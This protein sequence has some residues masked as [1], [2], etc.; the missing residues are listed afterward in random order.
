MGMFCFQCEQTSQGKG[1]SVAGVCGKQPST[2]AMQDL[3]VFAVK[4]ISKYAWAAVQK[5]AKVPDE[6]MQF[7]EGAIFTTITNV[8]FDDQRLIAM[9]NKVAEMKTAAIALYQKAGGKDSLELM[10]SIPSHGTL[11]EYL[12]V[13]AQVGVMKPDT[14]NADL[15]SLRE[16]L[17]YG[18]KGICAYAF[19]AREFGK[20]NTDAE[21]VILKCFAATTDE[22]TTVDQYVSLNL[23][24]GG[25]NIT[26]MDVLQNGAVEKYGAPQPTPVEIGVR[27]GKCILVSGHDLIDLE[28]LLKQTEGRG[29]SIYTHGEMLPAHGYPGL[30]KYK[31]LA[32]NYGG[33]WQDQA[34]EFDAFPGS[35]LM[36]TN[37]IQKPRE[38]YKARI[39][40]TGL[41]GWPGVTHIPDRNFS[42]VIDAALAAPGF[43]ADKPVKEILVGFSHQAVLGVADKVIEAVKT[44]K[45][46]RFFLIG[47][48]D[49]AKTGRN[50]FT[51]LAEK[52][53]QDCMILTLACGKYRFN[54]LDFGTVA[55]LPRLLDVG[56][57]NDANSAIKIAAALAGAFKCGLNDLPLSLVI[58]WYEQKAVIVLLSLLNLG[59]K[60]IRLGPSLP[61]F[62]SPA[63]LQVLVKNFNILPITT[64]D[65]DLQAM[66]GE[67]TAQSGA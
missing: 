18:L 2:A 15:R 4:G 42:K 52:I 34:T 21:A 64:A 57:C 38:S 25:A 61:A 55:G 27:K 41:V 47:G 35:I 56:Q 65:A 45:V 5:G 49:G 1:C 66:L 48:C 11:D 46:R 29:I 39:F 17:T 8:D 58:S 9:M 63:V 13:A 51:E 6:L 19:H 60:N 24:L 33:A 62:I 26:V 3:L 23:E 44:G 10:P 67:R 53:P 54:K 7:I 59:M 37:C 31:H 43:P 30:K 40:T 20:F 14:L 16:L 32:G 12:K 50:Y 28:A 36:T 22:N